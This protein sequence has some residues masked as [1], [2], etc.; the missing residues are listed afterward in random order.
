MKLEADTDPNSSY[1]AFSV[2]HEFGHVLGF[3]HEQERPDNI[4]NGAPRYCPLDP[5]DITDLSGTTLTPYFDRNSIMDYC[6]D[7]RPILSGGDV[8]GVRA[9]YGWR[10]ACDK[11]H[12]EGTSWSPASSFVAA[13]TTTSMPISWMTGVW[14][15]WTETITLE[16]SPSDKAAWATMI[17]TLPG[18]SVW[19]D[20]SFDDGMT[21]DAQLGLTTAADGQKS[22]QTPMYFVNSPVPGLVRACGQPAYGPGACTPWKSIRHGVLGDVDGDGA[23]DIAL[24]GGYSTQVCLF[25]A[26]CTSGIVPWGT[27]PVA[28]SGAFGSGGPGSFAVSNSNTYY[29]NVVSVDFPTWATQR[30][31]IPVMGDFNGNGLAD[32]AL[33]GGQGWAS[34][35]VASDY[36]NGNFGVTNSGSDLSGLASQ[37]SLA[38]VAGDFNGDSLS[39]LA[40]A[41]GAGWS[42]FFVYPSSVLDPNQGTY[43]FAATT[44]TTLDGF[45]PTTA[46]FELY[47]TQAT[48]L[49]AGDFDGDGCDDL[50]LV[51][52]AGWT[53]IPVA[54]SY[55]GTSTWMVKNT[56]VANFPTFAVQPGAT[57]VSGDFD[58]D[59]RTDIALVGGVGWG[60]IPVAFSQGDGSFFVTNAS[61]DS[62]PA[63]ASQSGVTVIAAD[64]DGDHRT[65]LALVGGKNA[66]G[67]PWGSVPVAFSDSFAQGYGAFRVTN[68]GV[69]SFPAWANV[70]GAQAVSGSQ[71]RIRL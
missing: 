28:F 33:V 55:C 68:D 45:S 8:S 3:D 17:S 53:T 41:G 23:G 25:K 70:S 66:D 58:G 26:T 20:R 51:G 18:D 1:F 34:V 39:D 7:Q 4:V 65:D 31:V 38:P 22:L 24:T 9:L 61:V 12:C 47:A 49:L 15:T 36:V 71:A 32:V 60:S 27:V 63:W 44:P 57:A 42:G 52:G 5:S 59:G 64:Y 40:V 56:P 48:Q 37:T 2:I 19:I 54:F 14:E 35:P 6:E 11:G 43:A 29:N 46:D 10:P 69:A 67:T 50:A 16:M 13:S 21:W 30:G 62:F